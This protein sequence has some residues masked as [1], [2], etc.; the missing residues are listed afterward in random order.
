MAGITE[1]P[2]NKRPERKGIITIVFRQT[3]GMRQGSPF[4]DRKAGPRDSKGSASLKPSKAARLRS[5]NGGFGRSASPKNLYGLFPTSPSK[6]S[7][8]SVRPRLLRLTPL[9]FFMRLLRKRCPFQFE[10]Y[11]FSPLS[12]PVFVYYRVFSW[13][14]HNRD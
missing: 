13:C 10:P 14:F 7:P 5:L 3:K 1:R 12:Y 8:A 2:V 9:T 11:V 6:P 4:G